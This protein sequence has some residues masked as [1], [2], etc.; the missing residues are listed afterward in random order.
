MPPAP[1]P[2]AV[3]SDRQRSILEALAATYRGALTRYFERRTTNPD[4]VPDL[5]Q[6]VFARLAKL[7]DLEAVEKP[8]NYLFTTAASTLKDRARRSAARAGGKHLAFDESLHSDSG[9]P[10]ERVLEARDAAR[11]LEAELRL[12]PEIARD[13]FVLRVFEGRKM[14]DAARI[15][16]VSLRT[17]E[18]HYARALAQLARVVGPA[19]P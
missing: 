19:R 7:D 15:M 17:A 10:L 6:D 18:K 14:A 1:E 16:Q 5:V 12:L 13:I 8:E 9:L 11:R 4:D 3:R 2:S